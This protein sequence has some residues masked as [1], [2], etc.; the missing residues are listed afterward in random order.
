MSLLFLALAILPQVQAAPE[1]VIYEI[2]VFASPAVQGKG[3]PIDITSDLGF[4]GA[5]CY[6]V[7]ADDVSAEIFLPENLT[8]IS[9][10]SI[11]TI[12]TQGQSSGRIAVD[13]GGKLTR[14]QQKWTVV[15][16]EYGVYNVTVV[17]TGRNEGGKKLNES[18]VVKITITYGA[19]ISAPVLTR[20]PVIDDDIII[21]TTVISSDAEVEEVFL[22]YSR[23]QNNFNNISM[24]NTEGDVWI[25][26]IPAQ[27]SESKIYYYMESVTDDGE[28]FTTEIYSVQVKDAGKIGTI[29]VL[30]TYGT[31]TAF[32]FCVGVMLYFARK[33][34]KSLLGKG[35]TVIGS[36]QSLSALGNKDKVNEAQEN[37]KTLRKW[38]TFAL[39]M[40]MVVLLILAIVTGQLQ[41]VIS[42]TTNPTGA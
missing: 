13:P 1:A 9:G 27:K 36:S 33:G 42:N 11:Q 23:N 18:E 29:K 26:V 2:D 6:T 34:R 37:L 32:I 35:M 41:D 22:Y 3:L 31:L 25:G 8:L 12:T 5:C 19:S 7:Y 10:S 14:F 4:G 16:D 30:T 15:A 24:K 20:N 38:I 21:A 40:I 39:L 28:T 17:V